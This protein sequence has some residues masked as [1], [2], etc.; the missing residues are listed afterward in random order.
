M[1][2]GEVI[3]LIKAL[4]GAYPNTKIP[5]VKTMVDSWTMLFADDDANIIY[6]AAKAHM[7]KSG[8]FPKPAE[9]RKLIPYAHTVYERERMA[10]VA[11]EAGEEVDDDSYVFDTGCEICPYQKCDHTKCVFGGVRT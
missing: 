2:R 7:E 1:T 9:I 6:R 8:W 10:S 4:I 5:D 3:G 11:I